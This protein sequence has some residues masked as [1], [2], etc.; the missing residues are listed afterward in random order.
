M[1]RRLM[2][3]TFIFLSG[4]VAGLTG[5]VLGVQLEQDDLNPRVMFAIFATW[6]GL[7]AGVIAA[8]WL[9][10]AESTRQNQGATANDWGSEIPGQ[11]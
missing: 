3:V 7:F 1:P 6:I 9:F 10:E 11:S 5:F 8:R 2:P 4:I